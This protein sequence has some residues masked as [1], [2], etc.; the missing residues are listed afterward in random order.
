[1]AELDRLDITN[2]DQGGG[3]AVGRHGVTGDLEKAVATDAFSDCYRLPQGAPIAADDGG[4]HEVPPGVHKNSAGRLAGEANPDN[5]A[6]GR[7]RHLRQ[8]PLRRAP[9]LGGISLEPAGCL[10]VRGVLG[11][12]RRLDGARLID[13]DRR[14]PYRPDVEPDEH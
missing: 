9:P 3:Q 2:P 4:A 10:A 1:M 8:R 5:L 6:T 11:G 7:G 13:G 14:G 12:G